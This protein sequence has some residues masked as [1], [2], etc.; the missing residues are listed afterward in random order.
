M[1]ADTFAD[2]VFRGLR[3]RVQRGSRATRA[4]EFTRCTLSVGLH[5]FQQM[6][7]P[8]KGM[9]MSDPSMVSFVL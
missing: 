7:L 4:Q 2:L 9:S 1:A 6:E 3:F 8:T 5:L